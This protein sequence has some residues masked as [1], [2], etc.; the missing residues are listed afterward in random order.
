MSSQKKQNTF[1]QKCN[2]STLMVGPLK[3]VDKFTY[4]GSS[5]SSNKNEINT[6]LSQVWTVIE[7]LSVI[8]KSDLTNA[9]KRSFF[10]QS[11]VVSIL[12]YGCTLWTLTNWMEKK[13]E[14]SCTRMLPEILNKSWRQHLRKR[15][16]VRSP[17]TH[18]R[19]SSKLDEPDMRNTGGEVR[20][21]S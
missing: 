8:W 13:L 10:V 6:R 4:L 16:A 1:N 3:L 12:L 15:A 2:I 17:T 20:M 19:K 5:V 11:A 9:I 14:N 7:R 21:Y 18:S